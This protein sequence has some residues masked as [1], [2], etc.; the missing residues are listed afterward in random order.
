MRRLAIVTALISLALIGVA[1][2]AM[3]GTED[4]RNWDCR[5]NGNHICGPGNPQH[6]K[7]GLYVGNRLAVTWYQLKTWGVWP[8]GPPANAR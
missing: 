7:P 5:S 3:A 1:T 6:L 2:P 4:S 8:Y